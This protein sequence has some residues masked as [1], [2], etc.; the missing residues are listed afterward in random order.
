[1]NELMLASMIAVLFGTGTYLLLQRTPIR[2]VLGL[3]LLSHGVNLLLL[4][5]GGFRRGLPPIIADKSSFTGDIS[6]FVD[7]LPQALILTA[8]VISFGVTAFM[9]MLIN[10]RNA[11]VNNQTEAANAPN[12]PFAPT[13]PLTTTA[14]EE[15][16]EYLET[17][18]PNPLSKME[19][20]R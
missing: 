14:T 8:I 6:A 1:M 13:A 18:P 16:Y 3:A 12:D 10:Q 17:S 20:R 11:L 9:V 5:S 7:P 15:D 4:S 19:K 2:L